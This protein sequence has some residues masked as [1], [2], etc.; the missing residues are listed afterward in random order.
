MSWS[1]CW[2][3]PAPE[4]H[5]VKG[6]LEQRGVPCVLR[7]EDQWVRFYVPETELGKIKKKQ[8][9]D[10]TTDSYPRKRFKGT[11]D[12]ITPISEFI[13]RN[14][15]VGSAF[16]SLNARLS[17]SFTLGP[18]LKIEGAAEGFNLTNRFIPKDPIAGSLS[19]NANTFGQITTS[20][21]AR[22]MQFALRYMF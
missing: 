2:S 20:G 21:D 19:L 5:L 1:G 14:A 22:V 4:A 16:V 9:V 10:V 17:R 8:T 12:E 18:S 11:I 13:P 15:G 3:G 6:F 7:T